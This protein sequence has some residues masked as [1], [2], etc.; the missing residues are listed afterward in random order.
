[1]KDIKV[2]DMKDGKNMWYKGYK[3]QVR[4][5]NIMVLKI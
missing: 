5:F 3:I 2:C 4:V 1:M